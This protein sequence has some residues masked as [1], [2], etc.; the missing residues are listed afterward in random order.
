M[1][2]HIYMTCR[3][4]ICK[5][6]YIYIYVC[7]YIYIY[8]YILYSICIQDAHEDSPEHALAARTPNVLIT[9]YIIIIIIIII[10]TYLLS[11]RY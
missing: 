3:F 8:I 6:I 5:F 7:M 4:I 9:M 10:I 1:Y 11:I 2:I